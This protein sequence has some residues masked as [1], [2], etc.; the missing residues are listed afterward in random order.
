MDSNTSNNKN[1]N[2]EKEKEKNILEDEIEEKYISDIHPTSQE[3]K[4]PISEY[5]IN[6][7]Q[8]P[9]PNNN[10]EIYLNNEKN[11]IYK[12]NI[13]SLPPHST[14]HYVIKETDNSS[15][16]FIRS[17]LNYI[18]NNQTLLDDT[19]L[20]FGICVQPFAEIPEYE[21]KIPKVKC[22]KCIFRCQKCSSYI[23]NKY[24]ITY[25]KKNK[26]III[27]NICNHENDF[28]LTID[29][30]KEECL[31]TEKFTLVQELNK[32]TIDFI[33][34][35]D[36][37]I[38]K[39]D[40]KP[41]YI[42]MIDIEKNSYDL[43][44]PS[45]IFN[46]IQTNFD[47]FN[48]AEETYISIVLY[49]RKYIYFF[50]CEKNDIRISILAEL[51]KP[52]C[53]ISPSKLFLNV[54]KQREELEKLF[55]KIN[56]F[57][58]NKYLNNENENKEKKNTL[59][60]ISTPT[61]AVIK[62]G[63][64]SLLENGGRV[65]IFTSNPCNHG[66]GESIPREKIYK[67]NKNPFYPQNNIYLDLAEKA[68]NNR[69]I[70]DQ[71]IFMSY[72]YDLSTFS[73]VSNLTGGHIEYYNYSNENN[74]INSLF[75]KMH[76][77][78]TRIIT[79]PNYNDCKFMIRFTSGID[80]I[81]ILG[82][83]NKKIAE[84]FQI[85]FCDPDF[86]YY[87]SFRLNK[88]FEI[89]SKINIQIVC[90]F[91][92]NFNKRYLRTF[93]STFEVTDNVE[94]IFSYADVDALTKALLLKE[95]SLTYKTDF[96]NVRQNLEDRII[97]SFKYYRIK[98]KVN[99]PIQQL[100]LP[101][102]IRYLPLYI[103]SFIKKGLLKEVNFKD[104]QNFDIN[105]II[106][107]R[108]KFMRIPIY[109][110]LKFLYPK[111]YRIDDIQSDQIDKLSENN[112]IQNIGLL[113]SK[114]GIIQKPFLLSLSKDNIDFDSAFLIDDGDYISIFIFDEIDT[115]FYYSL[116][117]LNSFQEIIDNGINS[118]SEDNDDDLN[119]RILNIISQLR[120]ENFGHFQ[121]IRIFFFKNDD[122]RNP[123]LS[124]LLIE[125]AINDECNYSDYLTKIHR[126]IQTRINS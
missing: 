113:N 119:I 63:I 111:F 28:D 25:N 21:N 124:N 86:C 12:T 22:D 9:R 67:E 89:G 33:A 71:F 17:T 34:P 107:L 35:E 76:Y 23:N 6:P 24:K 77:D 48:N 14:S 2:L 49:D 116:F 75:E 82:S 26:K 38:G 32:P 84:A 85:G 62:T 112:I 57:I 118:L 15:C 88:N 18:P 1:Y 43:G 59:N 121:P 122:I 44:L 8:I 93:N 98:E 78:L 61:G 125:D 117:K 87:Y 104:K 39:Y 114:F 81:E 19:N 13:N 52:F 97:N 79:R 74:I 108:F 83:F 80:C 115:D 95:I 7:K 66:F 36:F 27:C 41:H 94:K 56:L 30:V 91:N 46:S 20:L 29:G 55:E 99:S 40:F 106:S 5:T 103:N 109:T 126:Q 69:I 10:E 16:R 54:K 51:N 110:L 105:K 100:I 50:Y 45:F 90:L 64:D 3:H 47:Y 123:L 37:Q 31:N 60:Q 53:P 68:N 11:P 42:F 102:S 73:I 120:K 58:E 65:L 92:D 4:T 72:E 70:I 101:F 96:S